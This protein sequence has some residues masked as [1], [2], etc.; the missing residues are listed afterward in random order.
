M[1]IDLPWIKGPLWSGDARRRWLLVLL[2]A[3]LPCLDLV[4][5][6]WDAANTMISRD[7]WHYIPMIQDYFTGHFHLFSLWDTHSQHRTPGYKLLFL[8]NA[9]FLGLNM[10]FEIMLGAAAL[11]LT[12]VVLMKRFWDSLPSGTPLATA[13]I[14]LL[15]IA[16]ASTSLNQWADLTYGL[17]ALAG[18]AGI[19]CFVWLW[20]MLD[21]QLRLGTSRWKTTALSLALAFTLLVFAGG[22]G[23]ALIVSLIAVPFGVM[24]LEHRVE[25]GKLALLASLMLCSII[26]ELLY[27]GTSGIRLTSPHSQS[28]MTVFMQQPSLAPEYLLLAF[29]SSVLHANVLERHY[30]VYGRDINLV[31]GTLI[32]CI[33]ALSAFCYLRLRMW[34]TSYMPAFLM[35]FSVLFIFST[36]LVRLPSSGIDTAEAPRYV[37][38]S[39]L[40]FVGCLWTIFHWLGTPTTSRPMRLTVA[41]QAAL[42][43]SVAFLYGY[44]LNDSWQGS[45]YIVKSNE[46]AVQEILSGDFSDDDFVCHS[47]PM[48]Q[49]GRAIL[50]QYQ[51]NVFAG[52]PPA[53]ETGKPQP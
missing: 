12:V 2:V 18:Y 45:P 1:Y 50:A 3:T 27:W 37:Q 8:G 20:L 19:L 25:K 42:F 44:G 23:P 36:L 14:G 15:A 30:P 7:Q 4:V 5:Y 47:P 10:R 13:L 33:Y 48:C 31:V 9:I 34:K 43:V 41:A 29:T 35:M 22:M 32:F 53:A 49:A 17:T 16:M 38:Y 26:C 28:F 24:L 39:Q 21:S 46:H 51:L 11:I 6:T 40:G 52:H